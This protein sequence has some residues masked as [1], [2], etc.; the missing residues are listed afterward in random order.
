MNRN[1]ISQIIGTIRDPLYRTNWWMAKLFLSKATAGRKLRFAN[2][3]RFQGNGA[4][5]LGNNIQF[6][7][8]L[9][10]AWG[11]PIVIQPRE[12]NSLI[13]VGSRSTIMNGSCLIAVESISI[14]SDCIIGAETLI[15]DSDFHGISP[16]SRLKPGKTK[17]VVISD[18]VFIG[19]RVTILKGVS[20]GSNAVVGAGAVVSKDVPAGA[21]M[22]GNP[23]AVVG[24]AYGT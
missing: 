17:M 20:I 8:R 24:S 19:T 1:Y 7:Y 2:P 3:V 13:S 9:G 18:N 14:G 21:I 5:I 16:N 23:A 22:A 10:N 6:G 11:L 12:A 4:I 15:I